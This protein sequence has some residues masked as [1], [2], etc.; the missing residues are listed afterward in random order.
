MWL[1]YLTASQGTI[2]KA[3]D[4]WRGAFDKAAAK[5]GAPSGGQLTRARMRFELCAVAWG[6]ACAAGILSN[7]AAAGV[8]AVAYLY[9]QWAEEYGTGDQEETRMIERFREACAQPTNFPPFSQY[10]SVGRTVMGFRDTRS[11]EASEFETLEAPETAEADESAG[12]VFWILRGAFE[13]LAGGVSV[14]SAV[15]ALKARGVLMA[16][17]DKAARKQRKVRGV[18]SSF[19]CLDADALYREEEKS[20]EG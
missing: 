17:G 2:R 12:A 20:E 1:E 13:K 18:V 6:L 11:A 5:Y 15:K 7:D 3:A 8:D 4:K 9:A 14:K 16:G 19:Y 10:A